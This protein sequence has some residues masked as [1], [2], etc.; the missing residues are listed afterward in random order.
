MTTDLD[1]N[2]SDLVVLFLKWWFDD[3]A[4]VKYD[5]TADEYFGQ[6]SSED[7]FLLENGVIINFDIV[8]ALDE[9]L[10]TDEIFGFSFKV[11]FI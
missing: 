3:D 9:T 8:G 10:F 11:V 5:I 1:W 7:D 2:V 6:V 4:F